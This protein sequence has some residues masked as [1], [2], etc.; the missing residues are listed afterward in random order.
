M[1]SYD[2]HELTLVSTKDISFPPGEARQDAL[3]QIYPP[4]PQLGKKWE[5]GTSEISI[6]R[7]ASNDIVIPKNAVSRKHA[8][9]TF[10]GMTRILTDLQSTNGSYVNGS[11]INSIA[12]RQGDQ[13]KIGGTIFKYLVGSD[14]E[15][16]YHEEI[17]RMTII[18]GLTNIHNKRF[19]LG[20]IE[21]ETARAVRH[22]RPLSILMMDVDKFKNINDTY[23]HLAG[24]M[25]LQQMSKIISKRIRSGE[26]FARYGGEEFVILLPE[27]ETSGAK[28]FAEQVRQLVAASEFRFEGVTIPVTIS[29]GISTLVSENDTGETLIGRAD[30]RL[31]EAKANGRNCVVG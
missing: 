5:L 17:Y 7:D 29:I 23:G 30:E 20:E 13:I 6:G 10:D 15:N 24:D 3:V 28:L 22:S 14:V 27:T 9:V 26:L 16:A 19:F 31:Y 4:G 18:D 12:L 11:Q 25:V 8:K 21:R 2:E 1:T